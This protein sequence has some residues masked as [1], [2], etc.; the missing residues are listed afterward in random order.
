MKT[1]AVKHISRVDGEI[2]SRLGEIGTSSV[3][4]AQGR[5]GLLKPY[6]RPIYPR[7]RI[8]GHSLAASAE[9]PP[10]T[11]PHPKC[12]PWR[13]QGPSHYQWRAGMCE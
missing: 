4:E 11:L 10:R 8:G 2:A 6:M 9:R 13:G 12:S 5:T 1:V 3:H 7:A